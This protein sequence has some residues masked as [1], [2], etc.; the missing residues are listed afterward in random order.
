MN[1]RVLILAAIAAV[2]GVAVLASFLFRE[3]GPTEPLAPVINTPSPSPTGIVE[4]ETDGEDV[5]TFRAKQNEVA[6]NPILRAVPHDTPFWS[7]E[8]DGVEDDQYILVA[9]VTYTPGESPGSKIEQQRPFIEGYA[10]S[11]GQPDGT[12]L[13]RYEAKSIESENY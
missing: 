6:A 13:I 2:L 12:Y 1:R 10:R 3:A 8:F 9:Y 4:V 5:E 11:T 7:L